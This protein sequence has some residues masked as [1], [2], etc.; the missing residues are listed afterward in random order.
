VAEAWTGDRVTASFDKKFYRAYEPFTI[1]KGDVKNVVLNCKIANV[2]ASINPE[3]IIDEALKDYTV[4]VGNTRG[5]LDFNAENAASAHGYFMMP[6][7][8][9]SLTWTI[10]GKTETGEPFT[11]SGVIENVQRAHEYVLNIRYTPQNTSVGGGFITVTVDDT[12]LL[13]EDEVELTGAPAIEGVGFDINSN[14]VGEQGSFARKSVYVQCLGELSSLLVHTD[15]PESFG[16]PAGD[17][18]FM[19]MGD[20][21]R[22]S[23]SDAGVTCTYTSGEESSA[24]II[25]DAKVFN[26][27]ANGEYAIDFTA[28]DASGKKR[29][30]TLNIVVSNAEVMLEDTP[31]TDVYSYSATIYGTIL[32]DDVTNPGFRYRASGDTDWTTVVASSSAAKRKGFKKAS[33]TSFSA[34]LSG[35]KPGTRYEYQA[36][37]DGYVNPTSKYFTTESVFAIP[38][39]SFES[40]STNSKGAYI[41]SATG[42]V[43]FWDTGNHGSITLG[44]NITNPATSP[45]HS[46]TYSAFLKSQHVSLS[47][48]GK[49]AAGNIFAG[50]Y[51]KTVSTNGELTFGRPFDG[52]RPVKL[53]G[54]AYYH[55]GTVDYS[56]TELLKTGATDIGEIYVALT[57]EA[58]SIKTKTK[59]LFDP[60]ASYVLAYGHLEFTSDYGSSSEM[61]E[62]EITLDYTDAAL[63]Q[64]ATHLV[65]VGSASKYG[66]YFTGSTSSTLYIDDLELIY[67]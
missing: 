50:S 63:L 54:Y 58:V 55:P 40:W 7:G 21:A 16:L 28:T 18:D 15:T 52:S 17:F 27:L 41:P 24:R 20:A 30:R 36:L 19:T 1:T 33:A 29:S 31:W 25:F 61:R 67:K 46:G 65:I 13:I 38:N 62:F 8:D 11:K 42:A 12:E 64:K 35:L 59:Q 3:P 44:I 6:N 57:T 60:T 26:S 45:V 43:E 10:T 53:R 9:T 4:T 48:F 39:S 22:T 49:F 47:G 32:K 37:C 34:T 14:L 56:E 51:D 2:V 23:L 5:S 66:D